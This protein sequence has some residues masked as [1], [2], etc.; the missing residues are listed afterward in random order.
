[1]ARPSPTYLRPY[2]AAAAEHGGAFEAQLWRSRDAQRRRFEVLVELAGPS[3]FEGR[4]VVDL[5]CGTGGFANFLEAQGLPVAA[6]LG[7]EAVPE[8][9]ATA[10][11]EAPSRWAVETF[12]FVREPE[13]IAPFDADVAVL[14]G[15]LNTL[16]ERRARRVV[17]AIFDRVSIGVCFNFLSDRHHRTGPEDLAP[18]RRFST[19]GML[20]FATGLTPRVAFR[21]D[22]L[23]GHDAAVWIERPE[24]ERRERRELVAEGDRTG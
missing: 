17:A 13:R 16:S 2:L 1:M 19:L 11:R 6:G 14:S 15:S 5:G 22:H 23:D 21:Q 9:A 24:A 3:R 12:D 7:V 8:L 4:R 20:R 18:A 10:Q